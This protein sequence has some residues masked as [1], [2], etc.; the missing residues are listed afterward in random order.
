MSDAHKPVINDPHD[1]PHEGPIKTPKQLVV[2]VVFSFL[3]PI[4]LIVLLAT[5]VA[6]FNKPGAGT[7][8]LAEEAVARRIQPV[9]T[10]EIKDLADP[11]AMKTGEQVFNAQCAACHATGAAGAPKLGDTAAWAPRVSTG[12]EAL[13]NSALHGK[14]NMG[15]QG[16]GDFTDF[17]IG[18]AV[19]YMANKGGG[20]LKEPAMAPAGAASGAAAEAPASAA[21]N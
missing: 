9:G 14:G 17:E 18:R 7:D 13:L 19:V 2:T 10:V 11:A 21:S 1:M 4:F 3:I 6:G 16:G 20:N 12:Y 15:A 5:Y 8:L